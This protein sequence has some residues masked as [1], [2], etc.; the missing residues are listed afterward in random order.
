[1]ERVGLEQD[2]APHARAEQP[3]ASA[4]PRRRR[5]DRP[6]G[7]AQPAPHSATISSPVRTAAGRRARQGVVLP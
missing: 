1:V 4:R 3:W 6:G 5:S 2:Q 7:S